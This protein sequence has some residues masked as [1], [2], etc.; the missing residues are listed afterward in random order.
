MKTFQK[1]REN[2][3]LF[4]RYFVKE[5][6]IHA[7]REF[8]LGKGFH[9]LESPILSDALPQERYLDVLETK[10]ELQN[11]ENKSAYLIPSTETWNKRILAAGI[12]NHFTVSKVF[13][14]L[15]GIS[16]NHA[17]EFTM[18][19]WYETDKTYIDL[20]STTEELIRF[21]LDYINAKDMKKFKY[22]NYTIKYQGQ[23][24]N[25]AS[26][27][28]KFS[29][30]EL[31]KNYLDVG[32]NEVA[33]ES[34]MKKLASNL[35]IVFN[36]SHSWQDLFDIIFSDYIEPK[37]PLDKPSF[38][39]DYPSQMCP[40]TKTSALNPL[41]S[42]K[43]ELYIAGKEVANGYTELLDPDLQRMNFE[44][45]Q[46]EREKLGKRPVKLDE[47]IINA[48]EMGLP[49][50]SGIGLGIDRL[51][52]I[53]TNSESISDVNYFPASEWD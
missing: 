46:A 35:S 25:F 47:D 33:V 26:S 41:V 50:V 48:L 16:P 12:G 18:L 27:F 22:Q 34:G 15:E 38:I 1:L 44:R 37:L 23:K 11:G 32:V 10:I 51:V 8:F 36:N 53:L 9:E 13:R 24:I 4:E 14:G 28:N 5:Y 17:P 29:V 20:M 49:D 31:M 39:Y 3:E 19:E 7:I 6:T 30:D 43:V 2:P 21:I 52:M 42:E 45:E 40:L